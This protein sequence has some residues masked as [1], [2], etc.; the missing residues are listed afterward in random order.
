MNEEQ[1]QDHSAVSGETEET[2]DNQ[3]NQE[4]PDEAVS[5]QESALQK[6]QQESAQLRDSWTRERAEFLN[7]KKRS[8]QEQIRLR[9][10]SV[11]NFVKNL[12]PV[13]D[14]L[15]RVVGAQS[16]DPA[17]KN[18]IVGAQMIHQEF[19]AVLEKEKIKPLRAN[20]QPFD[21]N[22][23]EAIASESVE[24][25]EKDTVLEVYEEGYYMEADETEKYVIRPSRVKVGKPSGGQQV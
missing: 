4:N 2:A 23:M 10:I 7:F 5:G 11:A 3:V 19:V 22:V 17:V 9:S 16:E 18:F 15:E 14:N 25:L 6:C 20:G 24:G 21:P 8:A 1:N 13:L 12:L